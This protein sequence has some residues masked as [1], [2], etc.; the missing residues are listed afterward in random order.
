MLAKIGKIMF[1]LGFGGNRKDALTNAVT[2]GGTT[3]SAIIAALVKTG[4]IPMQYSE[5]AY[6]LAGLAVIVAGLVSGKSNDL[7][8]AN[9]ERLQ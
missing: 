8:T 6:A 1:S 7:T 3:A 4:T 2:V 5:L 9:T